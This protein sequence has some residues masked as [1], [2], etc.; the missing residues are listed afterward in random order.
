MKTTTVNLTTQQKDFYTENGYVL[1]KQQL[2]APE[3]FNELIRIFKEH[4]AKSQ[5][6]PSYDMDV[7]HFNDTRL[8]DF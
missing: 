7:P 2:F 3:K 6:D 8:L 5:E 4:L 1:P